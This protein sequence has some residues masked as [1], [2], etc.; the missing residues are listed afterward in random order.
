[1]VPPVYT[2]KFILAPLLP[3]IIILPVANV[4]AV[5][6][7]VLGTR[8][9]MLFMVV[10]PLTL[11]EPVIVVLPLKLFEPVVAKL[12]VWLLTIT[13]DA[14]NNKEPVIAT[15]PDILTF[16]NESTANIIVLP[17]DTDSKFEVD[18]VTSVIE[19]ILLLL[20][21]TPNIVDPLPISCNA[22]LFADADITVLPVTV[23]ELKLA[24][25]V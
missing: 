8:V 21:D 12:L 15:E 2:Y 19:N 13:L 4:P 24:V 16:L 9:S 11:R 7:V 3:D 22:I 6:V 10:E 20:P 1:V 18:D 5:G 14:F 25:S 17:D 23:S